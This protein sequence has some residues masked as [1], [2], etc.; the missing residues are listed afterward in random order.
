ME[1]Y[2]KD[3]KEI[4]FQALSYHSDV[5]RGGS[6]SY[7]YPTRGSMLG[8]CAIT[9]SIVKYHFSPLKV[10]TSRNFEDRT[11]RFLRLQAYFILPQFFV[12]FFSIRK[13]CS[14]SADSFQKIR[15]FFLL[16]FRKLIRYSKYKLQVI[17]KVLISYQMQ[18]QQCS[19]FK[20]TTCDD[21]L[22]NTKI[23]SFSKKKKKK[24]QK[25]C[26]VEKNHKNLKSVRITP[27][28]GFFFIFHH[29]CS[30]LSI[31]TFVYILCTVISF[32]VE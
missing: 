20:V 2:T 11:L 3:T 30:V 16:F 6:L 5:V 26:I 23:L 29:G 7:I 24:T 17:V 22:K 21:F 14:S 27:Q 1:D 13:F 18:K 28:Q 10:F 31:L 12:A 19:I 15:I 32:F 25:Q 8:V 9:F 4:K